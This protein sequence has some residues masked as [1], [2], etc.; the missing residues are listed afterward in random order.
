[1]TMVNF[2]EQLDDIFDKLAEKNPAYFNQDIL[3]MKSDIIK[4]YQNENAHCGDY[5]SKMIK[6][7]QFCITADGK[8]MSI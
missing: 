2:Y 7:K 4:A 5:I 6:V 3:N 8:V 1:M